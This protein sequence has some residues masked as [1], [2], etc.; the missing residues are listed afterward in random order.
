MS[1]VTVT[2]VSHGAS[3][4]GGTISEA[5]SMHAT[6]LTVK[7]NNGTVKKSYTTSCP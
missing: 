5:I 3:E 7:F 6:S 4:G 1:G 2:S